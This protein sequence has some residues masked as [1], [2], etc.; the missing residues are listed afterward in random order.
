MPPIINDNDNSK[1]DRG[2]ISNSGSVC[3]NFICNMDDEV[4]ATELVITFIINNPGRIYILYDT[5][6][7]S[8][9]RSSRATPNTK[10]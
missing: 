2:V 3:N 9:I 5:P 10:I 7:I 6:S 8:L 1:L 4:L